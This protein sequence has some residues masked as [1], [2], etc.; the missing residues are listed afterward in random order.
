MAV[1]GAVLVL[2]EEPFSLCYDKRIRDSN[3]LLYNKG[4]Q[5]VNYAGY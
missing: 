3:A 4:V 1:E 2:P 5:H